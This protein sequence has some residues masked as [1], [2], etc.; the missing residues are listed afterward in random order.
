MEEYVH[1]DIHDY[2]HDICIKEELIESIY[3]ECESC[4]NMELNV[5]YVIVKKRL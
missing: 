5:L 4:I 3:I 2:I 1:D